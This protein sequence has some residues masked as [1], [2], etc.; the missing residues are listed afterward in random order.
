VETS[1]FSRNI[2][3]AIFLYLLSMLSTI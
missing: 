1:S 2:D 3:T